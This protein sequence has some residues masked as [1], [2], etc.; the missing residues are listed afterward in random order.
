[1]KRMGEPLTCV[2]RCDST[3]PGMY[4][5]TCPYCSRPNPQPIVGSGR[6]L[7]CAECLSLPCQ[8][9]GRMPTPDDHVLEASTPRAYHGSLGGTG[10][11]EDVVP[12]SRTQSSRNHRIEELET[13]AQSLTLAIERLQGGVRQRVQHNAEPRMRMQGMV[14]VRFIWPDGP[15]RSATATSVQQLDM[16]F[17]RTCQCGVVPPQTE[18]SPFPPPQ[19]PYHPEGGLIGA[20]KPTLP[21]A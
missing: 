9:C 2:F 15:P 8:F 11:S 1:M 10:A 12:S 20:N 3:G 18:T 14:K 17:L 16:A 6:Y 19:P 21:C 4:Q 5:F 7:L 13:H